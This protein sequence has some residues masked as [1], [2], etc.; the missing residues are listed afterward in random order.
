MFCGAFMSKKK[1]VSAKQQVSRTLITSGKHKG[2]PKCIVKG[3]N[4]PGQ[5][6]GVRRKDGTV[7]RR[8]KCA[9]HHMTDIAEKKGMTL[10][11]YQKFLLKR[12]ATRAG[13]TVAQFLRQQLL[14]SAKRAGFDSITDYLNSKHKYRANRLDYCENTDG[15]LGFV[16]TTTI[17]DKCMLE[18][19]HINN[20]HKDNRSANHQTLCSCCHRYKTKHY[21]RS[22]NLKYIKKVF[23]K[24]VA[25][26]SKSKKKVVK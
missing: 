6:M 19:D 21:S 18:V 20:V 14:K 23:A 11:Q 17:T 1:F 9:E 26:F 12:R 25:K 3:C 22:K 13:M 7:V 24:N 16:C 4:N 8:A 2:L 10:K 15:R 5:H